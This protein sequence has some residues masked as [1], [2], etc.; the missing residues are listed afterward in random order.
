MEPTTIRHMHNQPSVEGPSRKIV[1]SDEMT[2]WQAILHDVSHQIDLL[3]DGFLT[4]LEGSN[5]Y[6]DGHVEKEDLRHTAH[7]TFRYLLDRLMNKPMSPYQTGAAKRLGARRAAQRVELEDLMA[8]IRLDFVVLW[9]QIRSVMDDDEL[10]ILV[11]HTEQ[12]LITIER[13][14]REVQLEFLSET[15]RIAHDARLATERH[16]SRLLHTSHLTDASVEIIA[17]GLNVPVDGTFEVVVI[18][19][20][21]V[22]EAQKVLAEQ[23]STGEILGYP[24][25]AGYSLVQLKSP[26]NTSLAQVCTSLAGGFADDVEGLAEVPRTVKSLSGL[27]EY[28]QRPS[29]LLTIDELWPAAMADTLAT[30]LPDFPDRYVKGLRELPEEDSDE[31]VTTVRIFLATGS[32]KE[33]AVEIN[34]HRNTVINRLKTFE[35]A[36]GLDVKVPR[37]AVIATLI[38]AV[39]KMQMHNLPMR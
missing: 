24:Y 7:E 33:T 20:S 3:V 1:K 21:A 15:A 31:I 8:A 23:L 9:R 22:P 11:E 2:A 39:P 10:P 38:L 28:S 18:H 4:E 25:A 30:L 16:V 36:T 26:K 32:V 5:L 35:H 34:R 37:D 12:L 14:I 19:E 17:Q 27:L 29:E 6:H 13:Y